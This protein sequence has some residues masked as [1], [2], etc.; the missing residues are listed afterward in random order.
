MVLDSRIAGELAPGF[1]GSEVA[2]TSRNHVESRICG[3]RRFLPANRRKPRVRATGASR[4]AGR[5]LLDNPLSRHPR[6]PEAPSN[7]DLTGARSADSTNR[8][9]PRPRLDMTIVQE[10]PGMV[11]KTVAGMGRFALH[12]PNSLSCAPSK[13]KN[14]RSPDLRR[15]DHPGERTACMQT[16]GPDAR[17]ARG[18]GPAPRCIFRMGRPTA[19]R[20]S[21][22]RSAGPRSWHL[23]R[24]APAGQ[25][26]DRLLPR[27]PKFR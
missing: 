12:I 23:P 24:P 19:R 26:F 17:A 20:S 5:S 9:S 1:H 3:L 18:A 2:L 22:F 11:R 6:I 25:T 27:T 7:S 16:A 15:R 4:R 21:P 8:D 10:D 13:T 14:Q